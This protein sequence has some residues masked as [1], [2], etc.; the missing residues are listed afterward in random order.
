MNEEHKSSYSNEVDEWCAQMGISSY[1]PVHNGFQNESFIIYQDSR[2]IRTAYH[3][4]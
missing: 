1:L 2:I 3:A 4:Q